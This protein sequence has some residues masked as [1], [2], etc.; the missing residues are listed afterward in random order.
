MT[1]T[2]APREGGETN[3][4]HVPENTTINN[5]TESQPMEDEELDLFSLKGMKKKKKKTQK[6]EKKKKKKTKK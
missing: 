1:S 4:L 5:T 3:N 2:H 6:K